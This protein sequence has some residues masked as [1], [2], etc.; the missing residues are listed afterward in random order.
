MYSHIVV[1][2]L[3]PLYG[4]QN[5]LIIEGSNF[6]GFSAYILSNSTKVC[7]SDISITFKTI[8][9]AMLSLDKSCFN[10]IEKNKIRSFFPSYL[11]DFLNGETE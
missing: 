8:E 4:Y 1:F 6:D 3:S 5:K 11:N 10:W 2:L 7:T 9:E